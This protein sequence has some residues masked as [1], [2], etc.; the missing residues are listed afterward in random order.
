MKNI[1]SGGHLIPHFSL[2]T[3]LLI[4]NIVTSNSSFFNNQGFSSLKILSIITML[5]KNNHK[6]WN[7]TKNGE[8]KNKSMMS[9]KVQRCK[10]KI[11]NKEE[12]T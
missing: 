10:T 2:C 1:R 11:K 6:L 3:T 12:K 5:N 4:L 7:M 8:I 9:E